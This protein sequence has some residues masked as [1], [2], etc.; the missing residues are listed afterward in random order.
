MFGFHDAGHRRELMMEH[1]L[2]RGWSIAVIAVLSALG[3]AALI[4]F[5]LAVWLAL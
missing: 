4:G 5:G 2:S 1:R 3:W